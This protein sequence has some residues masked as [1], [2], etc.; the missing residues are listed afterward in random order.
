M[1]L[2]DGPDDGKKQITKRSFSL[3][4]LV[5]LAVAGA[6]VLGA[7]AIIIFADLAGG[8]LWPLP[9]QNLP[10]IDSS[11]WYDVVR[12]S[13]GV[14]GLAGLGGGAVI[15]YRRQQTAERRQTVEEARQ[16]TEIAR[17]ATEEARSALERDRHQFEIEKRQDSDIA[18]L[19]SRYAKA[20]EQLGHTKAAVRLAGVY[21]MTALSDDWLG[22]GNPQQQKVC[23]DVLCAYLRMPYD[24]AEAEQGEKE[25]RLTIF[26]VIR[27]KLQDLNS[28]SSWCRMALD[29]TGAV[30]EGGGLSG[31]VMRGTILF[32]YARFIGSF[33][34]EGADLRHCTTSFT[35]ADMEQGNLSFKGS[36]IR[37]SAVSF[38]NARFSGAKVDFEDVTIENA[39]IDFER[40][41]I[42]A[43]SIDFYKTKVVSGIILIAQ[44]EM[45]GGQISFSNTK[46][47][48]GGCRINGW[49]F[50]NG[51]I[52]FNQAEFLGTVVDTQRIRGNEDGEFS[53]DF[54]N[55]HIWSVPPRVPGRLPNGSPPW[56]TSTSA[57]TE[58]PAI[59]VK[60][61]Q[62]PPVV[63]EFPF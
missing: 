49:N 24:P 62:W 44:P 22:I 6:L 18:D 42:T 14:V 45:F 48:G 61:Q 46:F 21:A 40:A 8:S 3:S 58:G 54:T 15:A 31:A 10:A 28:P 13:V 7:I 12:S 17:Q 43:G 5:V 4:Q 29:F 60:P 9:G 51:R 47:I 32:D 36:S 34:I 20:A 63:D 56:V 38:S 39:K 35:N 50:S 52:S 25:V 27:E 53:L 30:I 41:I 33:K 19:R 1:R 57:E 26:G 55:P 59:W 2:A 23:V 37:N 11:K 16:K